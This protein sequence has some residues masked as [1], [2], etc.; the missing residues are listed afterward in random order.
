MVGAVTEA[1]PPAPTRAKCCEC[2]REFVSEERFALCDDCREY[3]DVILNLP[4][5]EGK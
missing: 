2:G 1:E 5:Q 3:S 4:P